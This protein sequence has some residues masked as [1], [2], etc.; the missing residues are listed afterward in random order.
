MKG[1]NPMSRI[2]A[3]CTAL[4]AVFAL[5]AA[6]T[7]TPAFA[8]L[9]DMHVGTGGSYPVKGEGTVG[10]GATVVAILE[11]VLGEAVACTKLTGTTTLQELSSLGPAELK[12]TG[13]VQRSGKVECHTAGQGEGTVVFSGEYH[14]VYTVLTTLTAGA[15]I[16]F[17]EQTMGCNKEKLKIKIKAPILTKLNVAAGTE[18]LEYKLESA[19]TKGKQE[20]KEYYNEEEKLTPAIMLMNF[21]LGFEAGCLSFS[22]VT[23]KSNQKV[24]FLF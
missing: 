24:D 3:L 21:G 13:C 7:T 17:A 1:R 20:P 10:T 2:N 14:V 9:P 18:V 19:C 5:A 4:F 23:I 8:S 11:T 12:F 15:L 22:P 6:L 16:L